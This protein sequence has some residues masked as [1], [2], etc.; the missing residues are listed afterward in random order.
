M[1]ILKA[2]AESFPLWK[3][4]VLTG[5]LSVPEFESLLADYTHLNELADKLMGFASLSFAED[6]KNQAALSLMGQLEELLA[7]ARN[8]TLFFQLWWKD[9]EDSAAEPY[10]EAMGPLNY[11]LKRMRAYRPHSLSE[12]EERVINYKDITGAE[13]L[14][15]LYDSITGA[16]SF[17]S[18]F[19]PGSKGEKLS[20]EEL[21]MY[22]R[23]PLPQVRKAAYKELYKVFSEDSLVL[24]QIY[25]ALVR[26]WRLEN[27]RLRSYPS[28]Q[29]VRNKAN[30]LPDSVVQCLLEVCSTEA[31]RV[32][33]EYFAKKASLLGLSKLTRYDLYAPYS[34]SEDEYVPFETGLGLVNEAFVEFSPQL[35]HLALEV[36]KSRH[37]TANILKN[38]RSG[39]FCASILPEDIP[40]VLMSYKGRRQDLFT[41]A[42]ELGHA[43]HSQ[44]AKEHGIFQ[45]QATLPLAETASTFGEMLLAQKF[46]QKATDPQAKR[47][48]LFHILDDAY[49]TVARQAF[50]ALFE[51]EAHEL[52]DKG[53]TSSELKDAYYANL[54][55]QFGDKVE[56]TEEFGWEWISIPHF[57]HTPFYVY[58]YSF[59][60]L[61]VYSLWKIYQEEGE[62]F[63]P[64]FLKIL[65]AGGSKEPVSILAEAGVGPLDEKFW[66]GGFKV[67]EDFLAQI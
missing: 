39:A 67:I 44:L 37:L 40:W 36:D 23:S 4:K 16:Y 52:V 7:E 29:S 62:S 54:S 5:D 3:D 24:S 63:A 13:A 30:D 66:K 22:V 65:S 41:L 60:Q 18:D 64:R 1:A 45:Y 47:D 28:P 46:L 49:A 9:L 58:A 19:V 56:L 6:T 42:H 8:S 11:Y 17:S 34:A 10:L 57:F 27:I 21:S 14:V 20:R 31:P 33:G 51:L 50:F 59:G 43:V 35:A 25:Q 48:I 32:F 38:K 2:L 15:T 53:A 55:R 61:L 12:A 26:D